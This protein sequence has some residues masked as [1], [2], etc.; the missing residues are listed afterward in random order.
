M[1]VHPQ[2]DEEA[3]SGQGLFAQCWHGQQQVCT[4][5]QQLWLQLQLSSSSSS[6]TKTGTLM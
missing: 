5:Q 3:G 2:L 6:S 4:Q 1:P